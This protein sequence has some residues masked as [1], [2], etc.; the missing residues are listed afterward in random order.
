MKPGHKKKTRFLFKTLGGFMKPDKKI[1]WNLSG[2]PLGPRA[3]AE[4]GAEARG[5]AGRMRGFNIFLP[6]FK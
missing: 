5:P 2:A 3:G 1:N 4:A 6:S